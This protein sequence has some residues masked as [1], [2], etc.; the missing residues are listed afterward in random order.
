MLRGDG[1]RAAS[2]RRA[3]LPWGESINTYL[4]LK[5]GKYS[6]TIKNKSYN[7]DGSEENAQQCF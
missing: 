3:G 2:V 4:E 6:H 7:Q 5:P 1:A